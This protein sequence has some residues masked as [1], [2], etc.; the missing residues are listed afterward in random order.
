MRIHRIVAPLAFLVFG[1]IFA[2]CGPGAPVEE[3]LP[4]CP[5]GGTDLTYQTFGQTFFTTHCI[6]CHAAASGVAGAST[7]PYE[8]QAQI[9]AKIDAIYT[10]AGGPNPTMPP[11]GG[12]TAAERQDLAEWLSCGGE[13][14]WDPLSKAPP[15]PPLPPLRPPW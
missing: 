11:T 15:V 2:A 9:Q 13:C 4:D 12:P 1:S 7:F 3:G 6:T 5:E 14:R 10:R 8:T